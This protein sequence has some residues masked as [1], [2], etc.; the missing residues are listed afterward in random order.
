MR[1]PLSRPSAAAAAALLSLTLLTACSGGAVRSAGTTSGAAAGATFVYAPN[2]DVV[3]DWDPATSYSNE[4]T[5]MQNIYETLT[6]YDS[7]TKKVE[8]LLAT[9]WKQSDG[10]RTWTFTLREGVTFH[11]GRAMDAAAAKEAIDRTIGL[12]GGPAYIWDAVKSIDAPDATTLVFHL[13]YAA[14]LDLITSA[15]YGA[16]IYNTKA[17]G[18][19]DLKT[20]V[21]TG[22]DA[23][24]G[25]Y[26]VADWAKGQEVEVKLASFDGYW[27]G[28]SGRHYTN[29]QYRV[30]QDVTT[31]WQLLRSGQVSMVQRLNPQLFGEAEKTKGIATTTTPSFQNLMAFYN[32]RSG[33]MAQPGVRKAVRDA[34]DY[35]GLVSALKG[36]ATPSHGVVPEGLLGF[37]ASISQ[38]Q[39]LGA[40]KAELAAAGYGPGGKRL[41]LTMT[42]AQGDADQQLFATLL[43]SSLQQLGVTLKAQPL[44]WD[45]QWE[46]SKSG[47]L[48]KRQD[49]FVMYWY[50]EYADAYSWFVNLYRSSDTPYFNLSYW[51][52][53]QADRLI[54]GLPGQTATDRTG[55]AQT[56]KTLQSM[57]VDQDAVSS[58]LYVQTYQRALSDTVSGYKD[59]PAYPNV[60]FVY[61]LTPGA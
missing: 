22:R 38:Q 32:T 26:R 61:T 57:V 40:A 25:P 35:S 8:P 46:K 15:A 34:I 18:S 50:P 13:K 4:I 51:K 58:A 19:T 41:T 33:P 10:G 27:G 39:N 52:N 44:Q 29:V 16:Y 1:R 47:D 7:V 17:G 6:R 36:A 60:P 24:T 3:T 54:D 11:D 12:K 37:D 28:W 56:Y 43:S 14:A 2:L 21:S 59:N 49:I 42:Y 30:T 45:A 5:V 48:S 55:A 20:W 31:A 23:G 53:A 9:S